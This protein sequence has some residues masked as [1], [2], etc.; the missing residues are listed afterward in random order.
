[1]SQL[2]YAYGTNTVGPLDILLVRAAVL[3]E[4]I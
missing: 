4:A 2:H 1:M 3:W